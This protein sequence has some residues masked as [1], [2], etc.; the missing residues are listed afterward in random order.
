MKRHNLLK[1]IN[2]FFGIEGRHLCLPYQVDIFIP[3]VASII[4]DVLSLL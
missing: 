4:F 2:S 3:F 1:H